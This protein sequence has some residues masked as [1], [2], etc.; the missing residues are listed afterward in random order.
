MYDQNV[1]SIKEANSRDLSFITSADYYKEKQ[2]II[3]DYESTLSSISFA[4]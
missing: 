3:V 4:D 2:L 1:D